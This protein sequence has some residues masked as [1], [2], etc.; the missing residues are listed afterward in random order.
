MIPMGGFL[1]YGEKGRVQ[2]KEV[3]GKEWKERIEGKL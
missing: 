1:F 2:L 3:R